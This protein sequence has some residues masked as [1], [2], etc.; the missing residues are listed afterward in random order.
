MLRSLTLACATLFALPFVNA[1]TEEKVEENENINMTIGVGE[2][3]M[4]VNM[5]VGTTTTTRTTTTTT[6]TTSEPPPAAEPT[7]VPEPAPV[8][9][10]VAMGGGDFGEA[11][12]S[13]ASKGFEE[14]KLTVAKQILTHNC[15][16]TAQVKEIMVL[17]GFEETKLDF[18]KFAY[19]RTSD[20]KNYYK[21]NDAFSFESSISELD[22][23]IK[24]K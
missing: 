18:A 16:S 2:E 13:I 11:K 5:N 4:N 22:E 1:Q 21:L 10:C 14:S 17:F 19:D 7:P 3:Q 24:N 23:Y 20:P 6:T 9:D 12:Q 15:L 8:N